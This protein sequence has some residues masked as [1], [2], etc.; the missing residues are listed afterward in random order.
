MYDSYTLANLEQG[1]PP[2]RYPAPANR[3]TLDDSL[4]LTTEEAINLEGGTLLK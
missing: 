4:H 3:G 2:R 1:E